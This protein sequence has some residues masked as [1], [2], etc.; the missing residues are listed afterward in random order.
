MILI[1]PGCHPVHLTASFVQRAIPSDYPHLILPTT[2]N[3][4][5]SPLDIVEFWQQSKVN[6]PKLVII[7]FSAG[8]VGAVGAANIL[9][10]RQIPVQALIAIDGWG[11]PLWGEFPYHRLSHDYF[12]HWSS[13]LL[14]SGAYS[15]YADPA[16]EHL[17]M[18]RSPH[19]VRG[20]WVK[21]DRATINLS[22]SEFMQQLLSM[23]VVVS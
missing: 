3:S 21:G 18:W 7:A 2:R 14:G 16:V 12:T 20:W 19:T 9:T 11:V 4:P 23:Y 10:R 13:R 5:Y 17:D 15:F 6:P 1:C 8:V 22:A